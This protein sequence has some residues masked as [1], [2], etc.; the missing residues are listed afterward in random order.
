MLSTSFAS[1]GRTFLR[2]FQFICIVK[3]LFCI[4]FVSFYSLLTI[5]VAKSTHFCMGRAKHTS[6]F[7]FETKKCACA[8]Y[9]VNTNCCDDRHELLH[10]K[11]DHAGS[12]PLSAPLP[13][14]NLLSTLVTEVPTDDSQKIISPWLEICTPCKVP[15]YKRVHSLLLYDSIA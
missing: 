2:Y 9:N 5:G 13:E 14:F 7:S 8:K 10:I 4:V 1:M 11:D 15:I 3:R 12:Q 6:V